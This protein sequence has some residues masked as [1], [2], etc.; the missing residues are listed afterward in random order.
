MHGFSKTTMNLVCFMALLALTTNL[1][2]KQVASETNPAPAS[3]TSLTNKTTEVSNNKIMALTAQELWKLKSTDGRS[4]AIDALA[5]GRSDK[6]D[7]LYVVEG[8]Q[9]PSSIKKTGPVAGEYLLWTLDTKGRVLNKE[10]I[11]NSPYPRS[12]SQATIVPLPAPAGGVIVIGRFEEETTAKPIYSF[13]RVDGKGKIVKSTHLPFVS[14]GYTTAALLSDKKHLLLAS[15][16]EVQKTDLD[17]NV[18]WKKDCKHKSDV[19]QRRT[20]DKIAASLLSDITLTDTTGAFIA[21]G[22]VGLIN[23]F[24]LGK[25]SVWLKR[26][27]AS[28]NVVSETI[29]PGRRPFIGTLTKDRFILVYDTSFDW[30]H[31]CRIRAIDSNLKSEWEKETPFIAVSWLDHPVLACLS[32]GRGFLLAGCNIVPDKEKRTARGECKL[33]QYDTHGQIVASA[34]IPLKEKRHLVFTHLTCDDNHA[35]LAIRTKGGS[36]L[37]ANESAV[38]KIPLRKETPR[39]QK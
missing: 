35:Y 6:T 16:E 25:R 30:K 4:H 2:A 37:D 32:S 8:V 14:C 3:K 13:L 17:G 33:C 34:Q 24:G 38:F 29:F 27:N 9:D 36:P 5:L 12:P 21:V 10:L 28:G 19:P 39:K 18:I 15:A 23:K 11:A 22:D 31:D 20:R 1:S 26:C 7:V